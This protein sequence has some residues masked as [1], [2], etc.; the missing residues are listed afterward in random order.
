ML[1]LWP[2]ENHLL[3]NVTN[4][5]IFVTKVECYCV[6]VFFLFKKV[7]KR[8]KKK[9]FAVKSYMLVCKLKHAKQYKIKAPQGLLYET[10]PEVKGHVW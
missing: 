9:R 10:L 6:E 8:G 3:H 7:I 1:C 2:I 4:S 5:I